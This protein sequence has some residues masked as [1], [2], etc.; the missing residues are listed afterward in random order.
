MRVWVLVLAMN[1]DENPWVHPASRKTPTAGANEWLFVWSN[2]E[3]N[4]ETQSS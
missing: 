2:Q 1:I 3:N 4:S